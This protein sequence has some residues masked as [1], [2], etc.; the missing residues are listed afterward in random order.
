[1]LRN[2]KY[3]IS[4]FALLVLQACATV[5]KFTKQYDSLKNDNIVVAVIAPNKEI[6]YQ[7]STLMLVY[8]TDNYKTSSF[9]GIWDADKDLTAAFSESF[10]RDGYN[11]APLNLIIGENAFAKYVNDITN[12]Y[13]RNSPS[14][15]VRN[16][17]VKAG[18][19]IEEVQKR[20]NSKQLL[21]ELRELG[22]DKFIEVTVSAFN[23]GA[24]H[25][26]FFAFGVSK[27]INLVDGSIDSAKPNLFMSRTNLPDNK[28]ELEANNLA[29]LKQGLI[30]TF[31]T[32]TKKNK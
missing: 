8:A 28:E 13:D 21:S 1:M 6:T 29:L 7:N 16:N 9:D 18:P 17:G 5:P 30:S 32:E 10:N 25:S 27:T 23:F 2:S 4:I 12:W 11:A 15:V 24:M 14:P 3:L 22:Y 20:I 31:V 26:D 19:P